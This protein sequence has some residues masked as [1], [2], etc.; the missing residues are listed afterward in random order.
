M[1]AATKP[2][3]P[4]GS[5]PLATVKDPAAREALMKLNENILKLAAEIAIDRDRLAALEA[6]G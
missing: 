2:K 6:G 4:H 3:L 1:S 5:V